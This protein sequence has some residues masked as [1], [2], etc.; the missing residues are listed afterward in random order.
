MANQTSWGEYLARGAG[1]RYP[2]LISCLRKKGWAKIEMFEC[3]VGNWTNIFQTAFNLPFAEKIQ[4]GKF[5]AER[6]ITVGFRKDDDREFFEVRKRK[7]CIEPNLPNLPQFGDALEILFR[8]YSTI[9]IR[10][11]GEIAGDLGVTNDSIMNLTDLDSN[12]KCGMKTDD[13]LSSTLIR[14]CH[15][16]TPETEITH[17][18]NAISF[19]S[20]TDTSFI[21]LGL[22][23]QCPG[24]E[25]RDMET[26]EWIEVEDKAG[27]NSIVVMTGEYLQLLSKHK[28]LAA[29]HRVR[30]P[31]PGRTR[32][33]CP[34]LIRGR[35]NA[36]IR[37]E[38]LPFCAP[39]GHP[40]PDLD[41]MKMG[42]V[43]KMLELKRQKCR[44]AHEQVSRGD[45]DGDW[46]LCA[47]P[48]I[49]EKH[50][51]SKIKSI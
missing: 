18:I 33:S 43:H 37:L 2:H 23:S 8:L 3:G 38:R 10:I 41:G 22:A 27:S 13:E 29:N 24:L 34:C 20:H 11:L 25:V 30:A 21:T 19:G 7:N 6:G 42:V 47:F 46:T 16:F 15:Y 39:D 1:T 48:D 17:D 40:L 50:F 35:D 45:G 5:R 36:V 31:A 51:S 26:G 12:S 32:L 28:Y 44:R 9:G 14:I 4:S 49:L